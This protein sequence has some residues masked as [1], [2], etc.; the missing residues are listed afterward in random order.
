MDSNINF[1]N[2]L[3]ENLREWLDWDIEKQNNVYGGTTCSEQRPKFSDFE[4]I[5]L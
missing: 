2:I 4:R 5:L 1:I 3:I